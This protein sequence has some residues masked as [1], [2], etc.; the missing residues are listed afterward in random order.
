MEDGTIKL[1]S[2]DHQ[3]SVI[4]DLPIQHVTDIALLLAKQFKA[5]YMHAGYVLYRAPVI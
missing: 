3:P 4:A 1:L 2:L 5:V